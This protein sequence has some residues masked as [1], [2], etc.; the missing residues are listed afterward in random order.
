MKN[1]LACIVTLLILVC[2][3]CNQENFNK[4]FPPNKTAAAVSAVVDVSDPGLVKSQK[5]ILDLLPINDQNLDAGIVYRDRFVSS[6]EDR[7]VGQFQ[8]E[9]VNYWM[10]DQ[11]QRVAQL[12]ALRAKIS[13]KIAQYDKEA[14]ESESH[15][16]VVS[17]IAKEANALSGIDAKERTLIYFGDLLNSTSEFSYYRPKDFKLAQH[18][19]VAVAALFQKMYP[20]ARTQNM[21]AYL[22]FQP[23]TYEAQVKYEV[24][25]AVTKIWLEKQG[26][27]V[28]AGPNILPPNP[29]RYE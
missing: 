3:S 4:L 11:A 5:A 26:V 16:L 6:S 15:S 7:E 21:T 22:V 28:I 9:P 18:N 8:I 27:R 20:I 12:K 10:S 24:A 1:L 17:A 25:L 29:V 14:K 13:E 23:P 19:P 2:S